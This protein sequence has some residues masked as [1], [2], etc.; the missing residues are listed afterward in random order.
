[1]ITQIGQFPYQGSLRLENFDGTRKHLCGCA[2]VSATYCVSTAD[3]SQMPTS[4]YDV[5]IGITKRSETSDGQTIAVA[6]IFI[7]PSYGF[8]CGPFPNDI[9]VIQLAEAADLSNGNIGTIGMANTGEDFSTRN[10]IIS[11]WGQTRGSGAYAD[12]LQFVKVYVFT[13]AECLEYWDTTSLNDYSICVGEIGS[14]GSCYG[15]QGSPLVVDGTLVGVYS[16]GKPDCM[17]SQPS[18]YSSIAYFR[19]WLDSVMA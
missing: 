9:S 11:G 8:G 17:A 5:Q 18:V 13:Q 14:A 10:G 3:C 15:D 1:M 2:L 6:A 16:W 4:L 7:H 19:E 12:N